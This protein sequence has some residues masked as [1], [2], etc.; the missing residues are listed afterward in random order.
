MRR[1]LV[2]ARIEIEVELADQRAIATVIV[3]AH[4]RCHVAAAPRM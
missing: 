4:A 1:L 3:K 2:I